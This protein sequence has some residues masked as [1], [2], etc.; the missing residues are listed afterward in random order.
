M[1]NYNN[2]MMEIHQLD[3]LDHFSNLTNYINENYCNLELDTQYWFVEA[4]E[5]RLQLKAT[6]ISPKNLWDHIWD[7]LIKAWNWIITQ[8]KKFWAW[9]TKKK[10]NEVIVFKNKEIME[11]IN[12]ELKNLAKRNPGGRLENKGDIEKFTKWIDDLKSDIQQISEK[13]NNV[14]V[15]KGIDLKKAMTALENMALNLKSGDS[16]KAYSVAE[17]IFAFFTRFGNLSALT[18]YVKANSIIY[19]T[20]AEAQ[21]FTDIGIAIFGYMNNEFA[22][23]GKGEIPIKEVDRML[24]PFKGWFDVWF[25]SAGGGMSK[26]FINTIESNVVESYEYKIKYL[27]DLTFNCS[28]KKNSADPN[29]RDGYKLISRVLK[30]CS[31]LRRLDK[32]IDETCKKGEDILQS[33]GELFV[34]GK[35][36]EEKTKAQSDL[37]QTL[38]TN[39]DKT[40]IGR[41][42]FENI[43][44]FLSLGLV[45]SQKSRVS[46]IKKC[47]EDF[48]TFNEMTMRLFSIARM[49]TDLD[50]AILSKISYIVKAR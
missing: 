15:N 19:G 38:N 1:E 49:S 7:W 17:N 4:N 34:K 5:D 3:T 35:T 46:S 22:K 40:K 20:L 10:Y 41:N 42:V 36:P 11:R 28:F 45:D 32:K 48:K 33:F 50:A 37:L 44:H 30:N 25:P 2:L 16:L 18:N 39:I 31:E 21:G 13:Y 12:R 23:A 9:V 24:K 47:I 8:F 14:R 29:G 43:I 27:Y 26:D 6:G